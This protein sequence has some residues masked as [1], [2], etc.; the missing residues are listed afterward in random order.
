MQAM[1]MKKKQ[2]N[3]DVTNIFVV[4]KIISRASSFK[5]WRGGVFVTQL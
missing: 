3:D 5:N 4:T 2:T 1:T